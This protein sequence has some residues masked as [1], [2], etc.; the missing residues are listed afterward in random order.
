MLYGHTCINTFARICNVIDDVHD[1]N[2]NFHRKYVHHESD[3]IL[4][5]E[6]VV[7]EGSFNKFDIEMT[8]RLRSCMYAFLPNMQFKAGIMHLYARYRFNQYVMHQSF[9]GI[10]T[11]NFSLSCVYSMKNVL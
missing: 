2:V 6:S 9:V 5:Y 11:L 1:N 10:L 8:M 3:K 4:V 7:T